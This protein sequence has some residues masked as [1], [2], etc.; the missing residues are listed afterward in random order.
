MHGK[1]F[2]EYSPNQIMAL[3][4][5]LE[6]WLPADHPVYFI[7]DTV[8]QFDLSPIHADYR[9]RRGQP[10]YNPRMMVKVWF[11]GYCRGIRSSRRLERA[12]HEDVGFRILAANQQP[13]H[14]TLSEFRRR[15]H[16][17]LGDL[18]KETVRVAAQSGLVRL[19][20]VAVDGTKVKANAS[21]HSAMSYGRM[22][23]ELDQ[24]AREIDAYLEE[25]EANDAAEDKQFGK[26][27]G[28]RL[29]PELRDRQKRLEAIRRAKARLEAEA[30]ARAEAEQVRRQ[31]K[32]AREGRLYKPR[33]EA[34]TARPADKDQL[35]FTDPDSRIMKN[36]DKAFIQGYNAQAA[37][38]AQTHLIVAADLTNQA[39]D[40]PH[41]VS[42]LEQVKDNTGSA[43]KELSADAGYW[44][45]DNLAALAQRGIEAFIPP[46][47]VKHSEWRNQTPPDEP[48]PKAATPR[49]FMRHKLRTEEGRARYKLR[50]TSVEPVFG[51]I[52]EAMGFRQLLLRGEQKARSVWRFQCAAFNLMKLYW[53]RT[54][55][56]QGQAA[57][58]A[59]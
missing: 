10:P 41:L 13:D 8:D 31:D 35:N 28:W 36:S 33:K 12:L 22:K 34:Q 19:E 43:P 23:A 59:G 20:H 9:E 11:Y 54:L 40:A 17:A 7:S 5:S 27:S 29:P 53:H 14:W 39:S 21:K 56:G 24:A 6:E 16:R 2:R 25:V 32:A 58:A 26:D 38:D 4:P 45:E 50:Q 51:H 37:V 55:E 30:R 49:E 15:H 42:T 1:R 44:S 57:P 52:K 18:L 48:I 47:K 3:P 46:D